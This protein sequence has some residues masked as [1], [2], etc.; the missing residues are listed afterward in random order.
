M[1]IFLVM[2]FNM[3]LLQTQNDTKSAV[4]QISDI[5]SQVIVNTPTTQQVCK[6]NEIIKSIHSVNICR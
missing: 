3:L 2:Q 4:K 6:L 1:G 5:L